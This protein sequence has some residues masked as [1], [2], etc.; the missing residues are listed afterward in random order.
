MDLHIIRIYA[1]VTNVNNLKTMT[2]L[3]VS[4]DDRRLLLVHVLD[5]STCLVEDF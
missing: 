2:D 4:V 3:E 5:G 1:P